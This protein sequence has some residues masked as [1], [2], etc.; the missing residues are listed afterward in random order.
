VNEAERE[1][2]GERDSFIETECRAAS[3]GRLAAWVVEDEEV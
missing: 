3:R 1:R 2:K